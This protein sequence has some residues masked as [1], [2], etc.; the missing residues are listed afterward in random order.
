MSM[1][2]FE[3]SFRELLATE[4]IRNMFGALIVSI[5]RILGLGHIS[6]DQELKSG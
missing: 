1:G 5:F 6:V 3:E 4:L 2:K